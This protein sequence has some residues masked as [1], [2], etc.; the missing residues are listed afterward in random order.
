MR[1]KGFTLIEMMVALGIFSVLLV[2]VM[3]TFVKGFAAQ[4]KV[5]EMQAVQRDGVY[6]MEIISR[7][8]RMASNITSASGTSGTSVSFLSHDGLTPD[9][10]CLFNSGTNSCSSITGSSD[11][12]FNNTVINSSD[13][14][15]ASLHFY[16]SN[17]NYGASEPMITFSMTLQ[18]VKDPTVQIPFQSSAS[19]RLYAQH[20]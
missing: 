7:E 11:F 19:M 2:A 6:L 10:L 5:A 1:S 13:V 3:N 9:T 8:I 12:A 15:V 4:K 14:K 16:C 20:P 17:G 18:S